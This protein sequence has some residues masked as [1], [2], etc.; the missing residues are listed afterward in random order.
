MH[1]IDTTKI[2]AKMY[3][4]IGEKIAEFFGLK[5]K[6]GSTIETIRGNKNLIGIAACVESIF[7]EVIRK[8]KEKAV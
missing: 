8:E 5:I 6:K 4:T 7:A 1:D 3:E 2:T